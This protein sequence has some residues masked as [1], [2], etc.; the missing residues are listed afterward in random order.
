[1][2]HI[3]DHDSPIPFVWHQQYPTYDGLGRYHGLLRLDD[4]K[5][6]YGRAQYEEESGTITILDDDA[7]E[8]GLAERAA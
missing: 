3:A 6:I 2:T 7:A 1:M 5:R 8:R 4:A